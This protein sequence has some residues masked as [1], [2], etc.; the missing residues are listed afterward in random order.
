MQYISVALLN[1]TF[2]HNSRG[3]LVDVYLFS[4]PI[5]KTVSVPGHLA[6][7]LPVAPIYSNCE[8]KTD[9]QARVNMSLHRLPKNLLKNRPTGNLY[10]RKGLSGQEISSWRLEDVYCAKAFVILGCGGQTRL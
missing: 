5:S 6:V 9:T 1:T 10:K 2:L 8:P 4:V 3:R 7:P